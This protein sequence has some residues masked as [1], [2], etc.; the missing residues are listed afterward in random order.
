MFASGSCLHRDF[1]PQRLGLVEDK[2]G[3]MYSLFSCCGS[4]TVQQV[5][6]LYT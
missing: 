2:A 5:T 4:V 3:K 1:E 6:T